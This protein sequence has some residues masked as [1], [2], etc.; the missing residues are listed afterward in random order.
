MSE[1]R[2][3]LLFGVI[4]F[5]LACLLDFMMR[6]TVHPLVCYAYPLIAVLAY[7]LAYDEKNRLSLMLSSLVLAFILVLPIW[8]IH[9]NSSTQANSGEMT[10]WFG[11]PLFLYMGHCFHYAYHRD[12]S[13]FIN[14]SSLFEGVWNTVPFLLAALFFSSLANIVLYV[15]AYIFKSVNSEFLWNWYIQNQHTKLI[16][17]LTLFF[18]GLGIAQANARIIYNFRLLMLR[19]M[20]FLYPLLALISVVYMLLYFVNQ[21]I[22]NQVASAVEELL[23]QVFLGITFFNAVFQ[24][25]KNAFHYSSLMNYFLKVYRVVLLILAFMMITMLPGFSYYDLNIVLYFALPVLY[26]LVY[27]LTILFSDETESLWLTRGN[28]IVA[29]IFVLAYLL[30]NNPLHSLDYQIKPYTKPLTPPATNIKV[31]STILPVKS[32]HP[33]SNINEL[34]TQDL[35]YADLRLSTYGFFWRKGANAQA[36][37]VET[38]SAGNVYVCRGWYNQGYQIGQYYNHECWITFG[39]TAYQLGDFSLLSSTE[40]N[41]FTWLEPIKANANKF[42]ILGFELTNPEWID[43]SIR[44]LYACRVDNQ[45]EVKI[46]KLVGNFCNINLNG[47]EIAVEQFKVFGLVQ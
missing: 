43:S 30:I 31:Q 17:S 19:M 28:L 12:R 27:A 45:G 38:L 32:N 29:L 26:G 25:G 8:G 35:S 22:G 5:L 33:P 1:N 2:S 24:D 7:S 16:I 21:L 42:L 10:L 3:V 39:G 46:G 9:F 44:P 18:L 20:Y 15:G 14:Y 37:A 41:K 40:A 11:Y 47:Q 4:G 6:Y 34:L 36:L 23:P 13:I